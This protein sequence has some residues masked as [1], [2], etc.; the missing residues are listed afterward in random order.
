MG[1]GAASACP[2]DRRAGGV[3]GTGAGPERK[4][5]LQANDAGDRDTADRERQREMTRLALLVSL[6]VFGTNGKGAIGAKSF[7]TVTTTVLPG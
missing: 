1:A 4:P 5:P 3:H 2:G 7:V 6:M